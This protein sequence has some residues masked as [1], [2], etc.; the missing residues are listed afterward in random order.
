MTRP[1]FSRSV[2]TLTAT[3]A[4]GLAALGCQEELTAPGTCPA[5]CPDGLPSV[6]DTVLTPVPGGDSAFV[7]YVRPGEGGGLL[8]SNQ[9]SALDARTVLRFAAR[10]DSVLV[11]DTLRAFTID[12]VVLTLGVLARDSTV[13]NLS[14]ELYRLPATVDSNITLA[15]VDSAFIPANSIGTIAIGDSILSGVVRLPL[16]DTLL[17]RVAI[18]PGDSGVLALGVGLQG[19]TPTGVRL[20]SQ[21]A[22]SLAPSFITFVTAEVADTTLQAQAI[23]RVATFNTFVTDAV[24]FPPPDFLAIG[25]APSARSLVRFALP[26]RIKDSVQIV[27]A[28][29]ELVPESP[30]QGI[31]NDPATLDVRG[32]LSDLGA[33]SP[34]CSLSLL[35][36][37]TFIGQSSRADL[38]AGSADTLRIEV[39]DIVRGWQGERGAPQAFFLSLIPEAASFTTATFGSTRAGTNLPRLRITYARRLDFGG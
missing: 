16:E 30:L 27:R 17:S 39:Q 14:L 11:L 34:L 38:E 12:S 9:F 29:L 10:Q 20:G 22:G 8:V 2:G 13:S 37:G 25:G 18:P 1:V 31:P 28:T 36:G 33:K 4:L 3:L 26:P 24:G 6:I 19:G 15:Q 7:G 21:T 5:L 23:T 35:C 32:I